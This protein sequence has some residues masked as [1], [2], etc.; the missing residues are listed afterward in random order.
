[1]GFHLSIHL[2]TYRPVL[3]KGG[4]SYIKKYSFNAY[5]EQLKI[6]KLYNIHRFQ[7]GKITFLFKMSRLPDALKI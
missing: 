1:M 4:T 3:E 7:I 2:E 5:T 6:L